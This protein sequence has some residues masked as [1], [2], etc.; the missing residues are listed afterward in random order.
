[1]TIEPAIN[2]EFGRAPGQIDPRAIFNRAS[3]ARGIDRLGQLAAVP[4]NAGRWRFNPVTGVSEGLLVESQRTNLLLRSEEFDHAAWTKTS[5]TVTPNAVAAPDGTTTA[6]TLTATGAGGNVAQAV[7]I[8]AGRGIALSLYAKPAASNFL[9]MQVSD[10]TNPVQCWFNLAAGTAGTNTAGAGTCVF[11]QKLIEAAGNG[12]YRCSLEVTTSTST[13]FTATYG[14]AAA[15]NT[16]PANADAVHTWGAQFEAE[17]TV[18]CPTSYVPTTSASVTRSADNLYLPCDT[19]WYN[20]RE[21]SLV[22][23]VVLRPQPP[24]TGGQSMLL[25]GIGDTFT[26][27]IYVSR[28][29]PSTITTT[30]LSAAGNS[31]PGKAYTFTGGGAGQLLRVAVAWATNDMAWTL[32]GAAVTTSST[33]FAL[34]GATPRLAAGMAPWSTSSGGTVAH[35]TFL[36][37]RYFPRRLANAHLQSLTAP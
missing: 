15:D 6:D 4:A 12:W 29:G 3:A 32:N 14:P 35:A 16:A 11:S 2:W 5:L 10:G 18:N 25:G 17:S 27:T 28:S 19:R 31:T 24:V 7:T 20:P 34:A 22:F 30:F 33:A 26:N 1:M 37:F 13:A 36:A 8:T 21:G 23:E 9:W